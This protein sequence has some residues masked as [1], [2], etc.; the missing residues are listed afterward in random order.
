MDLVKYAKAHNGGNFWVIVEFNE[1]LKASYRHMPRTVEGFSQ[2]VIG[3]IR[4]PRNSAGW[5]LEVDRRETAH[6][7]VP[8]DVPCNQWHALCTR[9]NSSLNQ[10][11]YLAVTGNRQEESTVFPRGR[12]LISRPSA[13]PTWW[14]VTTIATSTYLPG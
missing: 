12:T 4:D 7:N 3:V 13:C 8:A 14:G 1:G 5:A 2:T 9:S 10:T 6:L 11:T